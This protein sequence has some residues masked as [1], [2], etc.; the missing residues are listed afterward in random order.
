[1][2]TL[3]VII[4]SCLAAAV[5]I[6]LMQCWFEERYGDLSL[7]CWT[8]A[9]ETHLL[10]M[11]QKAVVGAA[12]QGNSQVCQAVGLAT[13]RAG[14]MG[15]AL[16]FAAMVCQFVMAGSF[17]QKDFV[18]QISLGQTVQR[19]VNGDPVERAI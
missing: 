3:S 10:A 11:D 14:E 8:D 9:F 13:L 6:F 5:A 7:T 18:N 17:F 19:T 2:F 12:G 16:G 15:V 1:M 4:I